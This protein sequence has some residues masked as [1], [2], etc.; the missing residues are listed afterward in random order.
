MGFRGSVESVL[1]QYATF[2]GR[3]PRAE[4]WWFYLFSVLIGI[5]ASIVDDATGTKLLNP[6]VS[7]ALLLPSLAV[8]VRRL[9]DSNLSGWWILAPMGCVLV[10]SVLLFVGLAASVVNNAGRADFQM[11]G[12]G[13]AFLLSGALVL[14]GSAVLGIVLMLRSSTP[15]PNRFGPHPYGLGGNPPY[16]DPVA[17][18][19]G[20]PGQYGGQPGPYQGYGT[21]QGG[22]YGNPYGGR[23]PDYG[24]RS[25]PPE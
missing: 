10:G 19:G 22:P 25:N 4:Y 12:T 13:V 15:G 2:R 6:L 23:S 16:G 11:T 21:P 7:L 1:R 9:H 24:D 14:L 3:A 8:G 17:P 18:H 5:A 20:Q